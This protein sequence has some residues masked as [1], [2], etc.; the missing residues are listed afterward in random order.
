MPVRALKL[1]DSIFIS[2]EYCSMLCPLQFYI[3]NTGSEGGTLVNGRRLGSNG[4]ERDAVEIFSGDLL[5]FGKDGG[6]INSQGDN[7]KD[8][9][10]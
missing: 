1:T 10:K 7:G 9:F 6:K 8:S 5:Q 3:R 4:E 2:Y